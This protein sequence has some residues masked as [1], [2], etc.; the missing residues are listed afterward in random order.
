[1]GN[2][3]RT[4]GFALRSQPGQ[5]NDMSLCDDVFDLNESPS[6]HPG[7]M[8]PVSSCDDQWCITNSERKPST[9]TTARKVNTRGNYSWRKSNNGSWIKPPKPDTD[10]Y[11]GIKLQ[12]VESTRARSTGIKDVSTLKDCCKVLNFHAPTE[13]ANSNVKYQR[14]NDRGMYGCCDMHACYG[15]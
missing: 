3:S 6:H 8:M 12:D 14:K 15:M 1:M 9:Q 10:S 4:P 2:R 13:S 5:K 7:L 11:S